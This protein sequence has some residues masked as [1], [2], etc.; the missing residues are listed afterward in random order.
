MQ[1][2]FFYRG[3]QGR[4][5]VSLEKTIDQS[6]LDAWEGSKELGNCTA[7]IEFAGRAYLQTHRPYLRYTYHELQFKGLA[8][9][10][11]EP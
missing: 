10:T 6:I 9:N 11:S 8:T 3:Y 7:T 1:I 4:V 2:L 5:P